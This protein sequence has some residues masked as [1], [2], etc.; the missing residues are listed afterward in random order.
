[1]VSHVIKNEANDHSILN[2]IENP[3]RQRSS[4]K[5]NIALASYISL[6]T[7][8]PNIIEIIDVH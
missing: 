2:S 4:S 8:S 5:I 7:Q 3:H 1:M 6:N